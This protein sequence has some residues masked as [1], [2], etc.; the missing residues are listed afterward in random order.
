MHFLRK[1][2][3]YSLDYKNIFLHFACHLKLTSSFIG[4]TLEYVFELLVT[5]GFWNEKNRL[6]IN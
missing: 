5:V 3:F 1:K 6:G 4:Y 2:I